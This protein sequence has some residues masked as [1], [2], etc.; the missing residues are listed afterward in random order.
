MRNNNNC[1][2]VT[3]KRKNGKEASTGRLLQRVILIAI[4]ATFILV[5]L[6]SAYVVS[7]IPEKKHQELIN[8][9]TALH[10]NNNKEQPDDKNNNVKKNDVTPNNAAVVIE[11]AASTTVA[12]E[13]E[14][15]AKK[16]GPYGNEAVVAYDANGNPGYIHDPYYVKNHPLPFTDSF[17]QSHICDDPP[18][19]GREGPAGNRGL[20]KIKIQPV[21]NNDVKLLCMVYSYEG[22]HETLVRAIAETYGPH[23]DGFMVASNVTD[24]TIGA[25]HLGHRGLEVYGNMW[26]KVRA[27]WIYAHEHYLND[28]DWFHIGGDDM[29]VIPENIKYAASLETTKKPVHMGAAMTERTRPGAI[30]CGGGAGYTINRPTLHQMIKRVFRSKRC[31]P[32]ATR[33]D[34]DRT[35]GKCLRD[36][37]VPKGCYH[38]LDELNQT[39]YHHYDAEFHAT[40]RRGMGENW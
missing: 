4:G 15:A 23:C 5:F 11:E 1:R 18:G 31:F 30:Y 28:F 35:I 32:D 13:E 29:F 39:R 14:E 24:V 21:V 7:V 36:M 26:S 6:S 37:V 34:E 2:R 33:S 40:W 38:N 19:Q 10:N 8:P 12:K 22:N 9:T 17:N 16:E 25:V 27:M 20:K 3:R